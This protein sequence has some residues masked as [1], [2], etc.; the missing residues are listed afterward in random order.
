MNNSIP[1]TELPIKELAGFESF[2]VPQIIERIHQENALACEAVGRALPAI[3]KAL[4][5]AFVQMKAGGKLVYAG[6]GTSGRLGVMD[7]AELPVTFGIP[8]NRARA[9]LAGG[10][11]AF[12]HAIEGAE[13]NEEAGRHAIL[14]EQVGPSDLAVGISASGNTPFVVGAIHQAKEA[15][16]KTIG[17][18]CNP[19]G[20]ILTLTDVPILLETG[21]EVLAGSTRMKAATAQKMALTMFSTTLMLKLGYAFGPYMVGMRTH[22]AKLKMR[23]VRI[24][25]EV[26]A[27][28]TANAEEVLKQAG[29]DLKVALVMAKKGVSQDDAKSMLESTHGDLTQILKG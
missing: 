29:W 16:A 15:G 25:S 11:E 19:S 26:A 20:K 4:E 9:V 7:A 10:A 12:C 18:C 14:Q 17:L 24:L 3:A 28:K 13:D 23:A 5:G 22:N 21:Q 2:T 8:E 27:L 1:V 6:A